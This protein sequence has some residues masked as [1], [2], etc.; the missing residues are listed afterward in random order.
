[1]LERIFRL[2]EHGTNVRTEIMA[3]LTI[4]L[5][6]ATVVFVKLDILSAAGMPRDAVFVATCVAAAI[7]PAVMGLYVNAR[8]ALAPGSC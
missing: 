4:F 1:M 6:M 5:T 2:S 7:G 8:I 3:G